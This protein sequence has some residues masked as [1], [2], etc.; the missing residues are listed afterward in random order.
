MY[1]LPLVSGANS[2]LVLWEGLI[3]QYSFLETERHPRIDRNRFASQK[4]NSFAGSSEMFTTQIKRNIICQSFILLG[5][6]LIFGFSFAVRVFSSKPE[7]MQLRFRLQNSVQSFAK[8][9]SSW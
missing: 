1:I 8:E 4:T 6:M 7:K 5:S 3:L 2:L 9:D